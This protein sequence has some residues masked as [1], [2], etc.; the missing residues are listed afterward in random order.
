VTTSTGKLYPLARGLIRP[1]TKY[2][3]PTVVEGLDNVPA[4]G[5]AIIAPNHI[6]FL[7]SVMLIG[8]LPRRITYVGKAEYMDS[9]K[10]KYLFPAVG[11]I[12]LDRS[13]GRKS[14]VALDQAV[15][16]LD[17][18]E[19]FGIFPEGTRSRDG[20][21]HRGRTGVARLAL[22]SGA[23][24]I[25]VG[26]RGTDQIQ[27][28]DAR[29]PRPFRPCEVRFGAPIDTRHYLERIDSLPVFREL[30][31]EV[32]YEISQLSGQTYSDEYAGRPDPAEADAR[33]E[34]VAAVAG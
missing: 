15:D 7:D 25:P 9:W 12:P 11:M 24:V 17:R 19:L 8:V 27:P 21:L 16:V 26:I 32:L 2:L 23:P 20:L 5:P 10:T 28:P 22:R 34:L 18:G 4:D 33:T 29:F 6:S 30:T 3:W 31:D 13:G 14:M 1:A